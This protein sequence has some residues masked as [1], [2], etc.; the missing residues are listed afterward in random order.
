MKEKPN[1]LK[2]FL[3]FLKV[4]ALTFGGGYAIIATLEKELVEDKKWITHEDML[5]MIVVGESTPGPIAINL[6]TFIG[7]KMHGFWGSFLCTLG[8][9]LPSFAIIVAVSIGLNYITDVPEVVAWLFKGVRAGVVALIANATVKFFRRMDKKPLQIIIFL[10]AFFIEFFTDV[11]AIYL[12]LAGALVGIIYTFIRSYIAHKNDN[13]GS[14]NINKVE[15]SLDKKINTDADKSTVEIEVNNNNDSSQYK[16][17]SLTVDNAKIEDK[18]NT[19][20]LDNLINKDCKTKE[21]L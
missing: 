9:I 10:S 11:S 5:N 6:A 7:Y 16:N 20:M 17:N 13:N 19:Q 15:Q 4:G 18:Q 2:L 14:K 8:F 1:L 21:E 12:I 3:Y